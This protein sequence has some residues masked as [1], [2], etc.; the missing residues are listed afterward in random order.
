MEGGGG[1]GSGEEVV[2]VIYK[3]FRAFWWVVGVGC[4]SWMVEAG[5]FWVVGGGGRGCRVFSEGLATCWL[6]VFLR[7]RGGRAVWRG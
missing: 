4:G 1:W 2:A 7:I 3:R 6:R 5:L